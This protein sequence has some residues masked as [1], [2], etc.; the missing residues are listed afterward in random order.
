[1]RQ[2]QSRNRCA[3]CVFDSA[4]ARFAEGTSLNWIVPDTLCCA[5]VLIWQIKALCAE[6]GFGIDR[7]ENGV[8][9][10]PTAAGAI[11]M[12]G[13]H[14]LPSKLRGHAEPAWWGTIPR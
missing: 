11:E 4:H 12:F 7:Y 5:S 14:A 6:V 8:S 3:K 1:M 9:G 13:V 10:L 2:L